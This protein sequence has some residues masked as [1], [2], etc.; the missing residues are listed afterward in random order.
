MWTGSCEE[1]HDA[2]AV[3]AFGELGVDEAELECAAGEVIKAEGW[4][5]LADRVAYQRGERALDLLRQVS[6]VA[7]GKDCSAGAAGSAGGMPG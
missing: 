4:H 5:A 3:E 1:V 2:Q 7:L 6:M